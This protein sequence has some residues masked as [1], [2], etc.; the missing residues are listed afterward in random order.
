MLE[1]NSDMDKFSFI[2]L[3]FYKM[4]GLISTEWDKEND[5]GKTHIVVKFSSLNYLKK[6]IRRFNNTAIE[7]KSIMRLKSKKYFKFGSKWISSR[8]FKILNVPADINDEC[9][10]TAIRHIVHGQ[11]FYIKNGRSLKN[12][13]TFT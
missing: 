12:D 6:A 11:P 2:R 5:A 8:E 3:F 1:W 13:V 7:V 10:E 9:I 4:E